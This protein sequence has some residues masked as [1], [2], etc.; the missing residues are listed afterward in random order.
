M[1]AFE[2]IAIE[3]QEEVAKYTC[4]EHYGTTESAFLDLFIWGKKYHTQIAFEDGFMFIRTG[5][6][7]GIA[8]LFPYGKGDLCQAIGKIRADAEA[9]SI[10]P[11]MIG[12]TE[13]MREQLERCM[14]DQF[15]YTETRDF[16]DYVYNAQDLIQL[17]GKKLHAKRTNINKFMAEYGNRYA[18]EPITRENLDEVYAFQKRWLAENS[19][20]ENAE[21]LQNE[22]A[23][24]ERAI[25]HYFEIGIQGGF[26]RVDGRIAAYSMGIPLCHKF[27]LISIEK[28]DI[29][30]PGIY[31]VINKLF[32][33]HYC[34]AFRYINR[35][36]DTGAPGLR[37]AKLSYQPAFLIAKY[38]V[39]WK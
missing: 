13:Q 25:R 35:E 38:E 3:H 37:R 32:A 11:R 22:M 20:E 39:T 36:D 10:A 1:L 14:P 16:F 12:V 19:T 7:E 23:A 28:G 34:A 6:G 27:Y 5:D 21:G 8:Y 2:P 33:E 18:F 17:P 29:R 9:L 15:E 31:Q 24:I 30:Y 4:I 26:I